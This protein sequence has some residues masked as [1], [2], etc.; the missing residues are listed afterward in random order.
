MAAG[1]HGLDFVGYTTGAEAV[2]T[3]GGFAGLLDF[4]GYPVGA[5]PVTVTAGFRGLLD[6]IGYS[7]GP[8]PAI[9]AEETPI[10]GW[11]PGITRPRPRRDDEEEFLLLI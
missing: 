10:G 6:F 5:A 1:Q 11:S 9:V 7:V 4:I 2:T 8:G 3:T